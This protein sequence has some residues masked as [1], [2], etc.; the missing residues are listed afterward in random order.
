MLEQMIFSRGLGYSRVDG[1]KCVRGLSLKETHCRAEPTLGSTL[2]KGGSA[3]SSYHGGGG[4]V[5][6]K[7]NTHHLSLAFL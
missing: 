4:G 2:P 7:G 5:G 6:V 1:V 3:V